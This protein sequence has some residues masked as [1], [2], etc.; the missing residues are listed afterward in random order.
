MIGSEW[1]KNY[2]VRGQGGVL[3]PSLNLL[4]QYD[5]WKSEAKAILGYFFKNQVRWFARFVPFVQF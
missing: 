3:K 4:L 2:N 5:I 1:K